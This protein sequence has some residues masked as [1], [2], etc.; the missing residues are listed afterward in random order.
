V[1]ACKAHRDV[2]IADELPTPEN[3]IQFCSAA[4]DCPQCGGTFWVDCERC[5]RGERSAE[6]AERRAAIEAW[7]QPSSLEEELGRPVPRLETA[8]FQLVLDVPELKDGRKKVSGHALIHVIA[9]DVEHVNA[10]LSEHFSIEPADYRAKMRMWIFD[11]L[12]THKQA[13]ARFLETVSTGD[14]KML[15]RNPIFSVWTEPGNFDDVPKVRSLFAH[16]AA[17]MLL[18]NAFRPLWIGDVGGGW[19]DGAIGHWYEYDLFERTRQYC[20]EES[21]LAD[22]YENGLWRAAVRRRLERESDPFLP[23]LFPKRTGQMTQAEHALCFS[24]FEFL[25]DQHPEALKPIVVELK[26]K[27]KEPRDI[28]TAHTGLDLFGADRAW[29]EWVAARYPVKGDALRSAGSEGSRDKGG[30]R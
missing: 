3:P 5:E 23:G 6:V 24:F 22:N 20:I 9:R 1:L 15:G 25:L 19:L 17:H 27:E 16:N 29:R 13:M 2:P 21:T 12:E 14:F 30:R 4:A 8:R 7:R 18:S 26:Q 11:S 10:R 28:F